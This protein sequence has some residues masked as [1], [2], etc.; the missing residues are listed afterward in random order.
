MFY[1][2]YSSYSHEQILT[3]NYKKHCEKLLSM[4]TD[5]Q[6]REKMKRNIIR[7]RI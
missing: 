4:A 7:R 5:E 2:K 1:S 6:V 3:E